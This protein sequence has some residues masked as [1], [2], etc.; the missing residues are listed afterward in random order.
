MVCYMEEESIDSSIQEEE[1]LDGVVSKEKKP[2]KETKIIRGPGNDLNP[3]S[4]E[5][6]NRNAKTTTLGENR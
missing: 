1:S 3:Y 2:K 5:Y 4:P 6:K